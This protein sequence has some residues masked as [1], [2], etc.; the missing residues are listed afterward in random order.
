LRIEGDPRSH[1]VWRDESRG[2]A[3]DQR[4]VTLAREDRQARACAA[5]LDRGRDRFSRQHK[6]VATVEVTP[7]H[8]TLAAPSVTSGSAPARR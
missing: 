7:H 1:P 4:L 2:A 3:R 5:H 8:L 6:D